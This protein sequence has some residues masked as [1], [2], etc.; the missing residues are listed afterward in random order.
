MRRSTAK[1]KQISMSTHNTKKIDNSSTVNPLSA[2]T[3]ELDRNIRSGYL[4]L[5]YFKYKHFK[6]IEPSQ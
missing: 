3:D 4:D 1:A 2:V 6:G 5:N